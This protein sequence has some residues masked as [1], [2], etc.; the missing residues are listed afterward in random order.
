ML[1]TSVSIK[2]G[3]ALPSATREPKIKRSIPSPL[4]DHPGNIYLEGDL[5]RV[6]LPESLPGGEL[7]WRVCDDADQVLRQGVLPRD[8]D[9]GNSLGLGCLGIGWYRVDF[10]ELDGT[11]VG[12]TPAA[13]LARLS[14]P[15]PQDSPVCVDSA[16]AWF[17][18]NDPL[19]QRRLA[20]LAA[21]AG[22][23]WVRD[24]MRWGEMEP[25][26]GTFATNTTY[27]SSAAIHHAAGLK[28]LQVFHDTPVW[29]RQEGDGSGHFARDLR[30]VHRWAQTMASRFR[31]RVQAWEPWN[32]A[33]VP[34]FGG[35][36]V[37]EM[38]SWQKAAWLGFKAGDPRLI[39]GWNA[40]AAVPTE[41]HATGIMANETHPYFDTYNFHTYDWPHSYLQ[42]WP[43]AW[44]ASGG[45]SIWI[46]E[47]DRGFHHDKRAPWFDLSPRGERLKAEYLAQEYA[48]SLYAGADRHFHFILGH[49]HEPN[50]VQFGLLRLDLTPRPAYVALAAAGRFLAGA[51]CLGRWRPAPDVNI[52][53][54][55]A[56]PDGRRQDVLVM[57]AEKEVDWEGRGATRVSWPLPANYPVRQIYDYLGRKQSGLPPRE[58]TSSPLWVLAP[59]GASSCL[60]LEHP[61]LPV[62]EPDRT[63]S[64]RPTVV[65]QALFPPSARVR[66][67]DKPWS[68]GY[69]YRFRPGEPLDFQL[70]AY[71]FDGK[72][73]RGR[74]WIE[75]APGGWTVEPVSWNFELSSM[76]RQV[77]S[78]RFVTTGPKDG[79][80][81]G[82]WIVLRGDFGRA[83]WPVIAL[84]LVNASP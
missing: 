30:R 66:V 29:A 46:T 9:R 61:D 82:G 15:V 23:N 68:E 18:R 31:G 63:G 58:L 42:L 73:A 32:E 33:N 24:R 5:V 13:V 75:Q 59:S 22:V 76:D 79:G 27:D 74:V 4:P 19:H 62:A 60:P 51:R 28:V 12:W 11:R 52:V 40:T 67:E 43:P 6:A 14:A 65:L 77:R 80:I 81:T 26:N 71:Q 55:S 70:C 2:A 38:C 16:A 35:H 25:Q 56:Y 45:R 39:I 36:T 17:A 48:S 54:F 69:A 78:A 37:D 49:Y 3:S 47:A 8:S 7:K 20:N 64:T 50:G 34:S 83:G 10:L 41:E 21:L 44:T 84:R 57:W 53:A 1:M 72:P